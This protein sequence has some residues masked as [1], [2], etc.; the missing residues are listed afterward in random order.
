MSTRALNDGLAITVSGLCLIHCLALPLMAAALPVL[1][2]LAEAEWLHKGFVA[3][4]VPLA[5]FAFFQTHGSRARAVFGVFALLGCA[6]LVAGAFGGFH[7]QE[8]TLLTVA[9]AGLL[10]GAHIFRWLRHNA[11]HR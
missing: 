2:G 3:L 7:G 1:A 8:E 6:L 9:G 4:A 10:A 11:A 5:G